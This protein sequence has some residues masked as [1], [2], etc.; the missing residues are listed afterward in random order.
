MNEVPEIAVDWKAVASRHAE[1]AG[2]YL[3]ALSH[4]YHS[5][6]AVELVS[7]DGETGEVWVIPASAI[8]ALREVLS[9]E[10]E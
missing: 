6:E 3:D 1:E 7:D 9:G 2:R 8:T 10:P 4:L 5:I